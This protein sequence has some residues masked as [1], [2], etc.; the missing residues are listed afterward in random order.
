MANLSFFFNSLA[1]KTPFQPLVDLRKVPPAG[2][3]ITESHS[4][5]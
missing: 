2:L 1:M 3:L 5:K 4:K